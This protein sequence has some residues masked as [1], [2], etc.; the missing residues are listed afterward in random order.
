MT[1]MDNGHTT[2]GKEKPGKPK[3]YTKSYRQ[4]RSDESGVP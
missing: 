3:S 1:P 2:V 4:L